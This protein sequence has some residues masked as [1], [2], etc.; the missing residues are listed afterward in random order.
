MLKQVNQ[1]DFSNQSIFVGIDVHLRQWKVTILGEHCSFNTFSQPAD[2]RILVNHLAKHFPNATIKCAYEAGFSGF[3]LYY[4]LLDEGIDCI[5]VNPAD[6]PTKDN[7]KKRK[8]DVLDSQKIAKCLRA[9][10]LDPVYVPSWEII[11]I[12]NLI[13]T[14]NRFVT[15]RTAI[16]NKIK[17]FLH[18]NDIKIPQE[19]Q[20]TRWS[21]DFISWLGQVG[22]QT[23]SS[24]FCMR[25]YLEHLA[26]VEAQTKKCA[27]QINQLIKQEHILWKIALLKSIPGIGSL[28]AL[29]LLAE[30]D[31]INRFKTLD[32]L[33][34]YV[35][36]V[37]HMHSSGESERIGG[38]TIRGNKKL[39]SILI[40]S[41]WVAIRKDPTMLMTFNTLC[42]R[43]K[44]NK[45][46][47]RIA[48]KLLSRIR[49][50]LK[51]GEPYQ[52]A[53]N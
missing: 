15:Q 10:T 32:K 53:T 48:K 46:I 27:S 33:S 28:T 1:L 47:I 21:K 12:R 36:L 43:M 35:G 8:T 44:K 51:T 4:A 24:T 16:K 34:S 31:D 23:E 25:I 42:A 13:R 5:V 45:A 29:T 26:S 17:H 14:R 50:I 38:L 9:D 3:G 22:F 11:G 37:P 39:K 52:L 30:I 49:R 20:G 40:E 18:Y 2:A 19:F 41:S 7:E 6:V